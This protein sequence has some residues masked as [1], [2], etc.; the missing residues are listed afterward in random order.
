VVEERPLLKGATVTGEATN[1]A[2]AGQ[3][4]SP[5]GTLLVRLRAASGLTQELLA[6]RALLSR[7]AIAALESGKRRAPRAA[8]VE[9]LAD[10]LGLDARDREALT[11]AARAAR[12]PS[13]RARAAA[14]EAKRD[15]RGLS[16]W[17]AIQSTPLVDRTHELEMILRQ[18][19]SEGVRLLTLTGPA[20]VG[21]TCLA[22]AAAAQLA[23]APERFPGGVTLVDLT[24]VRDPSLMLGS[25]ASAVG[26]LDVSS[27]PL[28][29]RL[30]EALGERRQLVVLDNFE[31]VLPSATL[32][33]DLLASCS[34]LTLLVTS[35][36]PLELRWEQTLRVAPLP[37]PDLREALPPLDAL[38]AVPSVE[39]FIGRARAQRVDFALGEQHA[40]LVAQLAVKL[41]GL[42][43]ALELAAA[44]LDVL[45]LPVL[46]RRLGDRLRLLTA[47]APDR[48]ERQRSLE[49]AVGWSYDLLSEDEQ[50]LFRCLGVFA[51]RVTLDAITAVVGAVAGDAAGM[52]GK[53]RAGHM[54]Q[55]LASLAVKSLVLPG[56]LDEGEGGEDTDD[57]P[58]P[59]FG[60]LETVREYAEERLAAE[61]EL[62]AARRAHARY[63]LAL[64]E[65]ADPE[66][67]GRDQRAW[68]LR[69]EREQDNLRAA[70]RW[71]LDQDLAA[72]RRAG[73]RLAAALGWFWVVRGYP[74]EGWRWLEEALSR[75][76]TGSVGEEGDAAVH[77]W[78]LLRA[79]AAL[80]V[81]GDF[82]RARALQEEALALAQRRQA[83]TAIAQALTF[84]GTRAIYAGEVAE[85]ARL[86]REARARWEALSDPFFLGLTLNFLGTA[87]LAEG[88]QAEAAALKVAALE[89]LEPA[90]GAG[91]AGTAHLALA[92]I[93]GQQGDLPQAVR[94]VRAGLKASLPLR[95]RRLLSSGVRA[96]LVLVGERA[97][98]VQRARLLGASDVLSQ[99]TGGT[100]ISE[101]EPAYGAVMRL[102]ERLER[103]GWGAAYREGRA[104]PF[105]EVA[106]LALGLMED[107]A[108]ALA[109]AE[110]A[111]QPGAEDTGRQQAQSSARE[112]PLSAREAEVLRLVAQ[113]LS[114]KAMGRRL[115]LSP[116]T[117][118]HHLTAVFNKL[119]VDTRA[120][121]VAVATRR[122]L[123]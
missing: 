57:D 45:S 94:H 74:V 101:Q 31:Q 6:E 118:N 65:R 61:G 13:G 59:A 29:D 70:L 5:F 62:T 121:A 84:L 3:R 18:L 81:Q 86:L 4:P 11:A 73:L 114:S 19:R 82:A 9:L 51:G 15:V 88:D 102:R 40:P 14:R 50:R 64:A 108:R 99:T 53:G 80:M 25:I 110:P 44:R 7:A 56:Q 96:A 55:G 46:A 36:V 42:P 100:V 10:A 120:Q 12:V 54:L 72:E 123:L 52:A 98:P 107:A 68:Y 91:F 58:E 113:G 119:G 122:G 41:D 26:L 97:D 43:L 47:A 20:G 1:A 76:P 87:A 66:L 105:G 27:R 106:A 2:K 75:E 37:V 83:P 28:L 34:S 63:F 111:V 78:A 38:L 49:A 48:P 67:R 103:E 95:D 33:A 32:L 115:F 90:G 22:L 117:V 16:W 109:Q 77:I 69:L 35:R 112:T 24:P 21:K 8:T 60:M 17:L 104:L 92:A 23:D 89:R 116:S 85:G 39:L 71:L 30:G 79:G 93:A